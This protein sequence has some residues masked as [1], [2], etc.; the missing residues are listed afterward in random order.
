M[1][2]RDL[3]RLSGMVVHQDQRGRIQ[4]ERA[5]DDF[6]GIDRGV[7]D[8]PALLPLVPDQRVLAVEKQQVKFPELC[9][10][11]T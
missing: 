7:V 3:E 10:R 6:A 1:F 11:R 5:F 4:L 9:S 8:R 2:E